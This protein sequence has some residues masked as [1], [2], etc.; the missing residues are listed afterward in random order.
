M[1]PSLGNFII[2][3]GRLHSYMVLLVGGFMILVTDRGP[4]PQGCIYLT[5]DQESELKR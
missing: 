3:L 4:Y 2:D 5:Q 1:G